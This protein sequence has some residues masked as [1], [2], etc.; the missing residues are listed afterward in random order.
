MSDVTC[1][2]IDNWS[3]EAKWPPTSAPRSLHL[4]ST[5]LIYLYM[6]VHIWSYLYIFVRFL[7]AKIC[8]VDDVGC[9]FDPIHWIS[10]E[11]PG[12]AE[13]DH[14]Q[15]EWCVGSLYSLSCLLR[16]QAETCWCTLAR[17]RA[18]GIQPRGC[19]KLHLPMILPNLVSLFCPDCPGCIWLQDAGVRRTAPSCKLLEH[20]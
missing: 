5:Y 14:H 12:G 15:H 17:I 20:F 18:G 6:F 19:S 4:Y 16:W 8:S 7:S 11:F 9:C 1:P 3:P 2:Q 13:C 10:C